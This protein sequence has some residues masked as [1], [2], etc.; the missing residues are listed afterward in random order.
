MTIGNFLLM[1][2]FE[3]KS[4]F[5]EIVTVYSYMNSMPHY[6][7]FVATLMFYG[8]LVPQLFFQMRDR[9]QHQRIMKGDPHPPQRDS[10]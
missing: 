1:L 6:L 2:K 9:I 5:G 7:I 3:T 10:S 8:T 4:E